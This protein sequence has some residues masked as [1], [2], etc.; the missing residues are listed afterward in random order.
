M[1]FSPRALYRVAVL[2][3]GGDPRSCLGGPLCRLLVDAQSPTAGAVLGIWPIA[4][5]DMMLFFRAAPLLHSARIWPLRR[6]TLGSQGGGLA[7][8]KYSVWTALLTVGICLAAPWLTAQ[9]EGVKPE[10]QAAT[11]NLETANELQ[12]QLDCIKAE[13]A[14]VKQQLHGSLNP[15]AN[16]VLSAKVE[17]LQKRTALLRTDLD[18]IKITMAAPAAGQPLTSDSP[19]GA[20]FVQL[21][22]RQGLSVELT[23]GQG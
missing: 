2:V 5:A 1:P 11:K 17:D 4:R 13:L 15:E 12:R 6:N 19:T 3:V 23:R 14:S 8:M 9:S 20:K 22:P 7:A 21:Q 10:G 16:A 18:S